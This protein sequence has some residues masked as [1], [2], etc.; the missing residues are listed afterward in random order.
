MTGKTKVGAMFRAEALRIDGE[1]IRTERHL[2]VRNPYNGE[3]VGTL[4]MASLE[5]VRWAYEV[6]H[7]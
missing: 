1:K 2:D 3:R 6:A 5:Q 4:G 7:A